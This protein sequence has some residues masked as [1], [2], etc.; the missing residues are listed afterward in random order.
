MQSSHDEAMGSC[1]CQEVEGT[2]D[3]NEIVELVLC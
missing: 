3:S 2:S 1:L